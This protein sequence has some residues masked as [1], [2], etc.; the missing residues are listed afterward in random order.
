LSAEE[1][2]LSGSA[3][4]GWY[5]DP[6]GAAPFRWWD[7]QTWTSATHD[8]QPVQEVQPVAVAQPSYAT[9]PSYPMQTS[10]PMQPSYP[11]QTSYPAQ[12]FN[13]VLAQPMTQTGWERNRYAF[14][15]FGIVAFYLFVAM[16]TRVVFF[17]IF[18]VVMSFR[19]KGR[20]EP[21]ALF[22]IGAAVLSVMVAFVAL[23][24]R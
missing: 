13:Q 11:M 4:P 18:P 22:A 8:G 9:Q 7:G 17:G 21:L 15:T 10:Y 2:A 24:H 12:P 14:I 3:T 6:S 5:A 16:T 1:S 23:S 19:S 20:G